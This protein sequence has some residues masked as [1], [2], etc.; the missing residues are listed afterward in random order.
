MKTAV[1]GM[2][3]PVCNQRTGWAIVVSFHTKSTVKKFHSRERE[4]KGSCIG[5]SEEMEQVIGAL[6]RVANSNAVLNTLLIGAFGAL[7][8]RSLVQE[9]TIKA[10]EVE[11]DSLLKTNKGLKR[12]IWE[13][14]QTLYAEAEANPQEAL[15]PLANL[16]SIYGEVAAATAKPPSVS[17][18]DAKQDGKPLVIL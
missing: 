8:A 16:R 2:A 10:L 15:V 5:K 3:V 11:K 18:N 14:K 9:H 13:S 6:N 1:Q 7:A 12:T 17:G 4:G